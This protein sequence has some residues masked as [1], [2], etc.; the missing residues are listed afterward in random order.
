MQLMNAFGRF[1]A[2]NHMRRTC[3]DVV[4]AGRLANELGIA[5]TVLD[6]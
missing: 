2:L 1:A 4:S 5:Y 6:S 3:P